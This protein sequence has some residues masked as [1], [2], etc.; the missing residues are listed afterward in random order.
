MYKWEIYKVVQEGRI[1]KQN[2][3]TKTDPQ[4]LGK[5][6]LPEVDWSV[7]WS[8]MCQN[9]KKQVFYGQRISTE[10]HLSMGRVES[11]E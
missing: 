1:L 8:Q 9:H 11:S 4:R 3:R 10:A 2:S 6:W 5:L 7:V